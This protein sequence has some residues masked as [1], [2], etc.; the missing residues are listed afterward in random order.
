[1]TSKG[2]TVIDKETGKY[3]N[4]RK[5]ALLEGWAENLTYCDI[6]GF[7]IDEDGNLILLDD[8]G[9]FAHCP[10]DRFEIIFEEK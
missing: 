2:F 6:Y 3:P 5:I 4:T 7:A 1:M 10:P 8:C 9:N